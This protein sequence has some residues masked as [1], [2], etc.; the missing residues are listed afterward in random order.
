MSARSERREPWASPHGRPGS[1]L[2]AGAVWTCSASPSTASGARRRSW[3]R[4]KSLTELG[5]ALRRAG[6]RGAA[7]APLGEALDLAAR[8][9][10]RPLAAR[11]RQE[12]AAAGARPRRD[13]RQGVEALTPTELRVAHLAAA[14]KTNREIAQEL[15]VTLKTVEGHLAHTYAKLGITS[16]A[17]LGPLLG[18][19]K[20]QGGYPVV[21]APGRG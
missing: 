5:A 1:L 21:E 11:A 10:A 14:G 8:C 6:Q 4:A 7:R 16:R 20:V 17:E 3:N 19:G 9:G 15:Y 13:R 2:G 18:D 12:L